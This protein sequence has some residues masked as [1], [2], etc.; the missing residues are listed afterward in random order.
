M[1]VKFVKIRK[2]V[3]KK[4]VVKN[5]AKIAEDNCKKHVSKIIKEEDVN[6]NFNGTPSKNI[7][8]LFEPTAKPD[9]EA[10]KISAE[11]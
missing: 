3:I 1:A 11:K 5:S 6:H 9:P 4:A 7:L 10:V 8:P 2:R